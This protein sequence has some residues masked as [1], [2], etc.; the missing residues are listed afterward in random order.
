MAESLFQT[1]GIRRRAHPV[2]V[3]IALFIPLGERVRPSEMRVHPFEGH[4]KH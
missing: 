1:F 3:E 2:E 4:E